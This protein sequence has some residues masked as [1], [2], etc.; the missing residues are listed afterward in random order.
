MSEDILWR[1]LID[2]NVFYDH[3]IFCNMVI[4][5]RK[6]LYTISPLFE[7][8]CEILLMI[9]LQHIV[10]NGSHIWIFLEKD[11]FVSNILR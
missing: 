11:K 10:G 8:P 2:L 9:S 3:M 5:D 4:R 1:H 6:K 7:I